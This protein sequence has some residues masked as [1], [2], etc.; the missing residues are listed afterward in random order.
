MPA[1]LPIP[2]VAEIAAWSRVGDDAVAAAGRLRRDAKVA[3]ELASRAMPLADPAVVFL[4]MPS[5]FDSVVTHAAIAY[6]VA[7]YKVA[8][9]LR[10]A[11]LDEGLDVRTECLMPD[12]IGSGDWV[13]VAYSPTLR[14]F[15]EM[16]N[17]LPGTYP[18]GIPN[19]ASPVSAML[20]Q[21]LLGGALGYGLGM[22][23]ER[24]LPD[25]WERGRLRRTL[26]LMGML[27]GAVPGAVIG[28]LNKARGLPFNDANVLQGRP[29]D[30]PSL[31]LTQ[32]VGVKQAAFVTAAESLFAHRDPVLVKAAFGD[33]DDGG[34]QP[35]AGGAL[36][37]SAV[38]VNAFGQVLWES[39]TP[40]GVIGMT[41]GALQAAQQMPGGVAPGW[42]TPKQMG[43]LAAG[44][45]A[46]Y[47]SGA[48]VGKTLGVLAGMPQSTQDTLK[49]TGA[50]AGIVTTVIPKL[51]GVD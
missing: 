34:V 3:Q 27:G 30:V 23:G 5:R 39:Q 16:T 32:P 36:S 10:N 49:R 4:G 11:L 41:M 13:K 2:A 8:D 21:G 40:I 45:G 35:G 6:D 33:D 38:N 9:D 37:N 46:G 20:T 48:L 51:F 14:R 15:G 50:M 12:E 26:G 7:G 31:N 29:G 18:G 43:H 28:G 24:L 42:V 22:A 17:M 1:L 25:R 44:M 19:H 47:L